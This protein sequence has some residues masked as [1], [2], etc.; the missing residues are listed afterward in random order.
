MKRFWI[1]KGLAVFA[2][3]AWNPMSSFLFGQATLTLQ[4]ISS[5]APLQAHSFPGRDGGVTS[6]PELVRPRENGVIASPSMPASAPIY[7]V[8]APLPHFAQAEPQDSAPILD[9]EGSVE[10]VTFPASPL[11]VI[12][13][14]KVETA[15]RFVGAFN[16]PR[17]Q[18]PSEHSSASSDLNLGRMLGPLP[19]MGERIRNA[20]SS[21]AWVDA[22]SSEWNEGVPMSMAR[23]TA[24]SATPA[25]SGFIWESPVLCYKRL[26][27][28]QPNFERY[29][30]G[31]HDLLDPALSAT[32]FLMHAGTLPV[33]V[34]M[35]HPNSCECSLG[36]ARPGDCA[37]IQR[38]TWAR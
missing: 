20:K 37:P 29:G 13:I 27:F 32:K 35:N 21:A 6:E 5:H 17:S 26:Y 15:P 8:T 36:H 22:G 24:D 16:A 10:P 7:H 4:P 2:V 3:V 19:P 28:E 31:Y 23:S 1:L 11:S 25:P 33:A 9:A 12:P 18:L 30:N 34:L 38:H 14:A